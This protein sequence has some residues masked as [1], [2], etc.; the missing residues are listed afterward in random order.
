ML[1]FP[2]EWNEQFLKKVLC[3]YLNCNV[4]YDQNEVIGSIPPPL[5]YHSFFIAKR[6]ISKLW[7]VVC[8]DKRSV[9]F[10]ILIVF[11]FLIHLHHPRLKYYFYTFISHKLIRI[12]YHQAWNVDY[13]YHKK[14]T[15]LEMACCKQN[16]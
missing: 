5:N 11:V 1:I 3:K 13:P 8:T 7:K 14:W 9:K 12:M 2:L 10:E 15:I 16:S 6:A 4:S